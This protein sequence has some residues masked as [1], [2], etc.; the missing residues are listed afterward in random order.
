MISE[1]IEQLKRSFT[2]KF[3]TVL[4]QQPD[5]ARFAGLTGQIKTVN[6]S[7]RALVEFA[8]YHQ[9]IGWYDIDLDHLQVVPAPNVVVAAPVAKAAPAK[10]PVAKPAPAAEVKAAPVEKPAPVAKPQAAAKPAATPKPSGAKQSVADVLAA[11]R[12]TDGGAAA[13]APAPKAASKPAAGGAR[14]SVAE[15]MAAARA[16]DGAPV[17]KAPAATAAPTEVEETAKP[18]AAGDSARV[19]RANLTAA[20]I[21]AMATSSKRIEKLHAER[22]PMRVA[23]SAPTRTAATRRSTTDEAT[24]P[25]TAAEILALQ[26]KMKVKVQPVVSDPLPKAAAAKTEEAKPAA[27]ASAAKPGPA[28]KPPAVAKPQAAVKAVAPAASSGGRPSIAEMLELSRLNAPVGTSLGAATPSPPAPVAPTPVE[29]ATP[30]TV[31]IAEAPAPPAS[32]GSAG[33]RLSVAE[34]IAACRASDGG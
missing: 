32:N 12:A 7:G 2:D 20:D 14:M 27:P 19:S 28:V 1:A 5:L 17:A 21:L 11:A 31:V 6:M 10:A 15:M 25:M 9:N 24:S 16:N 3:V 33:G 22:R 23:T 30:E 18:Q 29:A 4:P 8:D 13:P 26:G 34:A